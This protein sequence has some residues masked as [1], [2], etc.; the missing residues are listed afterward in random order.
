MRTITT[1]TVS[2]F[3]AHAQVYKDGRVCIS[4]LHPPG[5]DGEEKA[6]ER[7]RPIIGIE[8]ILLSVVSMLS[9]PN[10]A[11]PANVE[12]ALMWRTDRKGFNKMVRKCVRVSLG[13]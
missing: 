13:V 11:S 3:P 9:D 6:E 5:D 10:C 8:Q 2:H 7:W 4:I 1:Q 12:A